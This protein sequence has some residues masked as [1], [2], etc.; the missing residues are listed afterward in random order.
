MQA[1]HRSFHHL[2]TRTT[3]VICIIRTTGL[4]IWAGWANPIDALVTVLVT[5]LKFH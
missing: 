3:P 4:A 1:R 2:A 5:L